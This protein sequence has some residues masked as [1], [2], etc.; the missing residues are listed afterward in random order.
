LS[1]YDITGRRVAELFNGYQSAGEHILNWEAVDANGQKLTTG[2]YLLQI[3]AGE[4]RQT[5]KMIY[6]R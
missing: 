1:V 3:T 6:A 5:V 2:V 4:Y